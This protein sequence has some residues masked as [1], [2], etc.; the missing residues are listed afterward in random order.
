MP[1]SGHSG[2]HTDGRAARW[3]GQRERRRREF[4][5]AAL[6]AIRER[7]PDVSTERIAEEAGVARTQLY[8]HFTDATDIHR[9]IAQRAVELINAE[10]APLW[11]LHGSPERMISTAVDTHIRW[12]AENR[13]LYRYLSRHSLSAPDTGPGAVNDVRT[14]I[15]EHLTVVFEHYLRAFGLDTRVAEPAAFSVVGLVDASTAQWLRYPRGLE[16]AQF[17][18]LLSRWV[19][20]ILDDALRGEGIEV[21]PAEPL[22]PPDLT[23]PSTRNEI[24]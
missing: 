20:S 2:G 18:A 9:T 5:E 21:D 16:H 10:L 6:R 4:V 23:F 15:G 17:A 11:E 12:L 8:K 24:G 19:W 14:T 3:A 13:H 22:P 7:G 1:S